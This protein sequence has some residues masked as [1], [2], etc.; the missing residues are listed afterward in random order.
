MPENF[1]NNF[2]QEEYSAAIDAMFNAANLGILISNAEGIIQHINPYTNRLFGYQGKELI[3]K[4]IEVL[5]PK[6]LREK[7]VGHRHRFNEQPKARAMGLGMNLYGLKKDN[8]LLPIEISLTHYERNGKKEI[9]SFISDITERKKAEDALKTLTSELEK[10]VKERTQELSQAFSELQHTN[11]N[12]KIE[13]Q[14][15]FKAEEEVRTA[16]E[17]EKELNELKS[18]FVSMASHE[19]RT[20]LSGILSSVTLISKYSS[21]D[22]EEKRN[23]HI[24]TI[25]SSVHNLT[26][27][28]NDFL[29]LDKLEK[30]KIEYHPTHFNVVEFCK[31]ILSELQNL[32]KKGQHLHYL[33]PPEKEVFLDKQ[34]LR[35]ILINLLSN[36]IKYSDEEKEIYFSSELE[37]SKIVFT[38]RD[39]GI[40]IPEL[41]QKHLFE[42]FF[43][44]TN[45]SAIQGT[46]L[47]LNIVKR[48]LHLMD[49]NIDFSSTIGKGSTFRVTLPFSKRLSDEKDSNH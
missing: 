36:A 30:G 24:Q 17:K 47:G 29:S 38:I 22:D 42:T 8:T 37:D 33:P 18:R 40:G 39:Q 4:K 32:C 28:L 41:E 46:G 3:G 14:Q 16:L 43:R 5:I 12:L 9:V 23:K 48:C 19:F 45:A 49:G 35:S 7:H 13:M 31:E 11:E 44:A 34:L 21:A 6:E 1:E 20:P 27:I 25:K 2:A 26:S 10:K 15:R